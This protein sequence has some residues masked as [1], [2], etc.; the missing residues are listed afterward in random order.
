MVCTAKHSALSGIPLVVLAVS[1]AN[2]REI[3]EQLTGVLRP[4][5]LV[6]SLLAGVTV[7]KLTRVLHHELVLKTVVDLRCFPAPWS[8]HVA[9]HANDF[10][11]FEVRNYSD[12]FDQAA[13]H[14]V[15]AP[16][17]VDHLTTKL[18]LLAQRLEWEEPQV[19][20]MLQE[21][22]YGHSLSQI[23]EED[24]E[25]SGEGSGSNEDG[26]GPVDLHDMH[27]MQ[28]RY[29][30]DESSSGPTRSQSTGVTT[31]EGSSGIQ[32]RHERGQLSSSNSSFSSSTSGLLLPVQKL[33]WGASNNSNPSKGLQEAGGHTRS[34]KRGSSVQ[35]QPR[36]FTEDVRFDKLEQSIRSLVLPAYQK[37]FTAWISEQQQQQQLLQKKQ[38]PGP[39][40]AASAEKAS[41]PSDRVSISSDRMSMASDR[42]SMSSSPV[43]QLSPTAVEQRKAYSG[44]RRSSLQPEREAALL[45]GLMNS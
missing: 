4:E 41:M 21:A 28:S 3:G 24:E 5:T 44:N 39:A 36:P 6:V 18:R 32:R 26:S 43:S 12:F 10:L 34:K 33:T 40:A 27:D 31:Q 14:M 22:M 2:L 42:V 17:Y 20:D 45:A 8:K 9:R 35:N 30:T 15:A 29:T 11:S 19:A 7:E 25:R 1:P 38:Q 37:V 23:R 13:R 16:G